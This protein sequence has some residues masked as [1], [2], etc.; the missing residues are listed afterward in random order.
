MPKAVTAQNLSIIRV[1]EGLLQ[2]PIK[3]TSKVKQTSC[4]ETRFHQIIYSE[5]E[6]VQAKIFPFMKSL[7]ALRHLQCKISN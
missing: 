6:T 5:M 1:A 7:T 3:P 4:L 2:L